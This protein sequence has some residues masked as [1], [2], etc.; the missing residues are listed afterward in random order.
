MC[1]QTRYADRLPGE[2]GAIV[3]ALYCVNHLTGAIQF[4]LTRILQSGY[5][6]KNDYTYDEI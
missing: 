6:N 4:V 2:G 1:A 5:N 3:V